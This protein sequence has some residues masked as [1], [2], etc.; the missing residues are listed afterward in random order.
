MKQK[1][2]TVMVNAYTNISKT[3]SHQIPKNHW[4]QNDQ[5]IC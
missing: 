5:D 2:S 4:T 1:V 3:N